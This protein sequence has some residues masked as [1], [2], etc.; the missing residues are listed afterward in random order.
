M[1]APVAVR[2]ARSMLLLLAPALLVP[3]SADTAAYLVAGAVAAAAAALVAARQVRHDDTLG[4][5]LALGVA[6]PVLVFLI[7]G[8]AVGVPG[9]RPGGWGAASAITAALAAAVVVSG[10]GRGAVRTA[11]GPSDPPSGSGA[12]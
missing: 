3:L 9:Y 10:L 1:P 6:V 2:A 12:P 11:D 4:W 8:H 5:L 7:V